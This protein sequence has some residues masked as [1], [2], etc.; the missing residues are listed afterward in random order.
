MKQV[1]LWTDGSGTVDG[2][3]GG[4]AFILRKQQSDGSWV[5]KEECGA[6]SATTNNRMELMAVIMGLQ[7]LKE[8]CHVT[9]Y[10][11]SEY[12]TNPIA[13]KWL[14]KW[15]NRGWSKI[16]NVDLMKEL[17]RL[18]RVHAITVH[19]VRGHNGTEL[20]ER[21]DKLAGAQRRFAIESPDV[22]FSEPAG[23]RTFAQPALLNPD[24]ESHLAGI[25]RGVA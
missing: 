24:D 18:N 4:W 19:W 21:C 15:K 8:P 11:D 9:L 5:E 16:K 1:E 2:E 25:V 7:A 23:D 6:A 12:A 13:K 22:W 20:N 17:D 3:P 14:G 10:A